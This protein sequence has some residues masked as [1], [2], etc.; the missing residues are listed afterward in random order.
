M[1]ESVLF[2][3]YARDIFCYVVTCSAIAGCRAPIVDGL[4]RVA[5]C[6]FFPQPPFVKHREEL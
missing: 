6:V 3:R 4:W 5:V 1:F 2:S